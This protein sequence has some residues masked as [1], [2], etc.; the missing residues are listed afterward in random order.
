VVKVVEKGENSE[1][2][3]IPQKCPECKGKVVKMALDQVA[4]RCINPSCPKQLERSLLHFAS[5]GAM[6][7][8]GFGEAV[9]H[10]LLD[11]KKLKDLADIYSLKK[12]KTC[13]SS[14]CLR[15][16]KPNNLSQQY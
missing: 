9:V 3:T 1:K 4:Y 5:R 15:R 8:E 16:R 13:C 7:I 2:V 11:R 12:E 6:D 10:Q 14:I